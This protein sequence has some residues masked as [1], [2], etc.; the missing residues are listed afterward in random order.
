MSFVGLSVS[1][2]HFFHRAYYYKRVYFPSSYRKKETKPS[3]RRRRL[4]YVGVRGS[5][6][7]GGLNF[8]SLRV[9]GWP[10]IDLGVLRHLPLCRVRVAVDPEVASLAAGDDVS[11]VCAEWRASAKVGSGQDDRPGRKYRLASV[12][13]DAS[14]LA[15]KPAVKSALALALAAPLGARETDLG[16]ELFPVGR[17]VGGVEGHG[18]HPQSVEQALDLFL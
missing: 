5:R 3:R 18:S 15:C 13:L 6:G 10:C 9:S 4:P 17:V 8:P 7:K 11:R 1:P 14:A 16:G 2:R 12:D